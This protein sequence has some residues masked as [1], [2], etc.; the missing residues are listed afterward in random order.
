MDLKLNI[1]E[2]FEADSSGNEYS[3]TLV[4]IRPAIEY[5][6][7]QLEKGASLAEVT[8]VLRSNGLGF[9]LFLVTMREAT[10]GNF[11]AIKGLGQRW[12]DEGITDAAAFDAHLASSHFQEFDAKVAPMI[13]SKSVTTY[14]EVFS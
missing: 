6:K 10:D 9:I 12:G 7:E 3:A 2:R 1:P 14:S 5:T 13:A 11:G 8:E 4:A